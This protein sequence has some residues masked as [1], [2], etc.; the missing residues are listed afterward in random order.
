M[1]ARNCTISQLEEA[2][3][4]V[5]LLYD[6]QV[7][8]NCP[9]TQTRQG[10]KFTLKVR[11]NRSKGHGISWMG[12]KLSTACWHVH[13]DFFECLFAVNPDAKVYSLGKLITKDYGNWIDFNRG[14]WA[15]P[16]FASEMCECNN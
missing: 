4:R 8:F 1:Y 16:R 5:N 10:I 9:P 7:L 11:T 15:T 12:R 13:G 2:L 14:N 3:F 6:D